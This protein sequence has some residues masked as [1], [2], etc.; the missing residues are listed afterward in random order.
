MSRHIR[1]NIW[2]FVLSVLIASVLYPLVLLGIGQTVFHDKAQGS[3]VTA[4]DG[5]VIGSRL[6]AQPFSA[7]EYF[8]PRP[9]AASYNGAASGASNWGANNPLLRARVAQALG[10]IVRYGSKSAKKGQPVGPDIET[11]FQQWPAQHPDEQVGVVAKWAETYPSV[12]VAW[13]KANP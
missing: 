10:P 11:W 2:L 6:I 4:K 8:Q 3:L 9:S 13:V 1:A 12:A 7:D 5:T